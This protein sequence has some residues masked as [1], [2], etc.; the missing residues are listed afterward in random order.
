MP[1]APKERVKKEASLIGTKKQKRAKT[2]KMTKVRQK[3][4][5]IDSSK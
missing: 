3:W 1:R 5:G 2:T 4:H